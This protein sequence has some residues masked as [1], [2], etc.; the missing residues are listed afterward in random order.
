LE[1]EIRPFKNDHG[2]WLVRP[3]GYTACVGKKG[4]TV[5]FEEFFAAIADPAGSTNA[6]VHKS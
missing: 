4:D 3:D 2:V 1:A 5:P 6:V